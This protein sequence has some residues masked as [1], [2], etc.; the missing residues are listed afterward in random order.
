MFKEEKIADALEVK[1]QGT[2]PVEMNFYRIE[3]LRAASL[4][5]SAIASNPE[6]SVVD[7]EKFIRGMLEGAEIIAK[8]LE[9][10]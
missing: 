8:Y 3:A 4:T 10:E 6:T 1:R 9:G 7:Y 2:V 5:S